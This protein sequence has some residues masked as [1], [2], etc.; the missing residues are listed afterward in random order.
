MW[1]DSVGQTALAV[2]F[3]LSVASR[4][5][6]LR[7]LIAVPIAS[8]LAYS[9]RQPYL[10]VV[11]MAALFMITSQFVK[12]TSTAVILAASITLVAGIFFATIAAP[13]Y[14]LAFGRYEAGLADARPIMIL[15][16]MPL[17]LIRGVIGP[18]PWYQI[19]YVN[20]AEYLPAEFFQHVLNVAVYLILA[21]RIY[22]E[23]QSSRELYPGIA[24]GAGLLL[25]GTMGDGIHSP[26]VSVGTI[27]FLPYVCQVSPRI[28]PRLLLTVLCIFLVGNALYAG[29]GLTD[30]GISGLGTKGAV[31]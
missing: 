8:L 6:M 2:G 30:S 20:N 24:L 29:L 19:T 25:M 4:R 21:K 23:W 28:W 13:V 11:P 18:W 5:S 1:R 3:C 22:Q 12:Q 15:L 10:I 9:L 27:F 31:R 16:L 26:Y 14:H 17:R 7:L